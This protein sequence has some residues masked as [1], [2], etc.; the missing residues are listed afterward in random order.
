MLGCSLE[1]LERL[2]DASASYRRAL[3][4]DP[5][6]AKA[7]NNL[8][9]LLE[10]RG[11]FDEALRRYKA[12]VA[13]DAKLPQALLNLGNLYNRLGDRG[14]ALQWLRRALE[15]DPDNVRLNCS[16]G[17]VCVTGWRL[18]EALERYSTALRADPRHWPAHFGM[19]NTLQVLGRTR[20]AEASFRRAL[21]L[22]AELPEVHSNLL[23]C[24][25][26][27]L[28]D[29][30]AA[31]FAEHL[32]W[33]R[34]NAT[35]VPRFEHAAPDRA[36]R[37][38]RI[39]YVSPNFQQHAVA[40]AIEPVFAAHDRD[41][42]SIYFYS[43]V[44]EPDATTARFKRLCDHWR[45]IHALSPEAEA[46]LVRDD[47]IDILVDLA[48]H[49]GGG[50]PMLFA[51][52]PAPVQVNWQGY[53][54]TSGMEEVGYR[55]TDEYADPPG[56]SDRHHTEKLVRLDCGFFCYAPPP[57]A[58]D[59][60]EPPVLRAGHVTFG[61]FNNLAKVT[62]ETIDLWSRVLHRVPGSRV[63]MKSHALGSD[64]ARNSVLGHFAR[65]GIGAERVRLLGPEGAHADHLARYREI[66]I[67][68]E[69][70][71]YHGTATTC[72]ALW[73]GVPVVTLAGRT[74][75]ARV[76]VS[77]LQRVGV[78]ELIT[79]TPDEYVE[80]AAGLAA[81]TQKLRALRGELRARLR[82]SSLLDA[83]RFARSL[84]AAYRDMWDEWCATPAALPAPAA[85]RIV[86]MHGG[87]R[88]CVPAGIQAS[89]TY[90]LLE[91]EDWFED[92]IQF[93]RRWLRAGMH[94]VDVGANVGV[95]T[96]AM[97]AAVGPA[98]RVWAFEPTTRS[99]DFLQRTLEV[100]GFR[101]VMLV[102][103][104]VSSRTGP[105]D[106][107]VKRDSELNA[108]ATGS[109]GEGATTVEATTLDRVAQEQGWNEVALVKIDVEGHEAAVVD[110]GRRFL[111]AASPLVQLEVRVGSRFDLAALEALAGLGYAF[112]RLLPHRLVLAPFD[113]HATPDAYQLNVFACKADRAAQLAQEGW[114]VAATD[115]A[116]AAPRPEAWQRYA[117]AAP[118]ARALAS[119]WQAAPP[120]YA[121]ALAAYAESRD[122]GHP[123]AQRVAWLRQAFDSLLAAVRQRNS[124]ARSMSLARVAWELGA[125]E[126]A[127]SALADAVARVR[128]EPPAE[129]FLMP[130]P[131]YEMLE[132]QGD[133]TDWIECSLI[134]QYEKLRTFS[135]LFGGTTS[136]A[137]LEPIARRSY[138]SPE[139]ERRRQ[140]V[141]MRAGTQDRPQATPLL[142]RRGAENL[143]P[144]YWGAA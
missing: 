143:N 113:R 76:G 100:N 64:A 85:Q 13:A 115:A 19:G 34:R 105:L 97:A 43:N 49:T 69:P 53:P 75:V 83:R 102:R 123:L 94:A 59:E 134:E 6:M 81:D 40:W 80:L 14:Q 21:E 44:A 126:A 31:M 93:V 74:H 58:P 78:P 106:F 114:L 9:V 42:F 119:Q 39:G 104:A 1:D 103:S 118:Y 86:E 20:E 132:P 61:S 57:D 22:G 136:A 79:A 24:L 91:Q 54:N 139:M 51:R 101:H 32:A 133:L 98:G 36:P 66:D 45:D 88:M 38:L 108:V 60:G 121:E 48:V 28:G 130:S 41:A 11:D 96:A 56:E 112:F 135:S 55:I 67:G 65:N 71:P 26:Y 144:E 87:V 30:A 109:S 142:A 124:V 72:E 131:R 90:V 3:E 7:A 111:A 110:G 141:A 10:M 117:S 120:A 27:H 46:R 99:A 84:E 92:E 122:E 16:V 5:S 128:A 23:L 95:Y 77:I 47:G 4:L 137:V 25:H 15:I 63:L 73:M 107:V 37:R 129:A 140:L 89:S 35:L 18:D 50:R 33:A 138:R 52:R 127:V 12:A 70:F 2:D 68:L 8:G 29:D 17:E 116:T 62:P 125:R 82:G